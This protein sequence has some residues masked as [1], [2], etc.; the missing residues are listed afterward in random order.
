MDTDLAKSLTVQGRPGSACIMLRAAPHLRICKR[1]QPTGLFGRKC[2]GHARSHRL[3]KQYLRK[4]IYD[5]SAAWQVAG[6][7]SRYELQGRVE[8][9]ATCY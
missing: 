1:S 8:R 4:S 2:A 3:D 5:S 7:L 6:C 9:E